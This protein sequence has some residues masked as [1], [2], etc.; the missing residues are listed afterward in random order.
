MRE[1]RG[2]EVKL[3]IEAEPK[4]IAA[5]VLAVQERQE[6]KISSEKSTEADK[7]NIAHCKVTS[8]QAHYNIVRKVVQ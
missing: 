8:S 3:I 1:E 4:E 6:I 5:L 7:N 2:E